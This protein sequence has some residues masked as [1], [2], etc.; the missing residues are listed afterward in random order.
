MNDISMKY[1]S[2]NLIFTNSSAYS[3]IGLTQIS[4]LIEPE[5]SKKLLNRC[6]R[7]DVLYGIFSAIFLKLLED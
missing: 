7:R 1:L 3:D 2:F 4:I 5:P 6:V